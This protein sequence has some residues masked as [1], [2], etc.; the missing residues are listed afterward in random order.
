MRSILAI[1]CL[2]LAPS[3]FALTAPLAKL[4]V[5]I[6]TLQGD[7]NR[8]LDAANL[9][10]ETFYFKFISDSGTEMKFVCSEG[11]PTLFINA[12][13]E[14]KTSAFYKGL[15]ELGF[16]FPH[17]LRQISPTLEDIKA[18]CGKTWNWKP[19]MKYRGFHLHT[20]HPSEWVAA[21]YQNKPEIAEKTI[22]WMA[23]NGQNIFDLSLLDVPL[24]EI[25]SQMRPHFELAQKFQINTG[26]SLGIALNQQNS[27]KLL[28]LWNSYFGW[29]ADEKIEKGLTD[30]FKALPLSYVV[31]EAG[32]SEFTP[33]DFEKTLK[34][35][36]LSGKICEKNGKVHFTKVHV[37]SN[38]SSK[39]FG[40]YNFLPHFAQSN[41]GVLPHTVMFYGVVDPS[42]PMYGNKNFY[43][44][45]DFMLKENVNRPT[46]YY[47][48]TSYW[49]AMDVDVPLFLTDYLRTRALDTKFLNENNI[50][51]QLNFTT[52]HAL[53]YWLFDWNLALITDSDY[54]F[55]PM[56][57]LRLLGEDMNTWRKV[58][59]YQE[60]WYKNK[61]L[62]ALLSSANLQDELSETHRIHDR[63]T[64]KQ[65]SKNKAQLQSEIT[66][67]K[68]ALSEVPD[69]QIVQDEEL[70]TMLKVNVLRTKH[71]LAIREALNGK[72]DHLKLASDFRKSA[73][74]L[75]DGLTT[76][77]TNYPDLL[78]FKEWK[79][80]TAYQFGYVFPAASL[81]F[82]EREENQVRKDS[83]FPFRGNMYDV[84]DI[85]F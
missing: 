81:Y 48:E 21:F 36:N 63:F 34:W 30:L 72:T 27:Y 82:W 66:L 52:G 45:R 67:L 37:S 58:F 49:V 10:R 43:G 35:L 8:I 38:Q 28:S 55:D 73:K 13:P 68:E 18:R 83:Y 79:N 9:P 3:V 41:V 15:R 2:I 26:V 62:I 6:D 20:L 4:P 7:L 56:T 78:I 31:L 50:E 46:W 24:S 74:T 16:L 85:V 61:G 84:I 23:R 59:D 11:F 5:D 39:K 53:G 32:T 77:P 71:A 1:I 42:A 14:E 19:T 60:K 12:A 47:P 69:T 44:I 64:M 25:E 40:N 70:L 65:L 76:R 22:R 17:P 54:N 75:I 29:S 51:G 33:T 80:P 57:G